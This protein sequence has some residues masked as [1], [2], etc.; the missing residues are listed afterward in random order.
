MT[1]EIFKG[2]VHGNIIKLDHEPG[3]PDGQAVVVRLNATHKSHTPGDGLRRAF[4]TWAEQGAETE[5]FV[6]S[7][8]QLRHSPH[9][10]V[11]P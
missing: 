4:G 9:R 10:E 7:M 8:R 11:E 6:E 2:T 5:E 3:L 1:G